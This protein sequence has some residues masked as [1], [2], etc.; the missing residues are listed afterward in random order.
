MG[1]RGGGEAGLSGLGGN[2]PEG[3]SLW[4]SVLPGWG[5]EIGEGW[6][7]SDG[8]WGISGGQCPNPGMKLGL[9]RGPRAEFAPTVGSFTRACASSEPARLRTPRAPGMF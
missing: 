4:G 7:V 1:A 9:G 8:A 2:F 5:W 3:L 6:W